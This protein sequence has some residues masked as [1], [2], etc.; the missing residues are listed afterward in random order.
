MSGDYDGINEMILAELDVGGTM[1]PAL[2]HFDR[3]GFGY[4]HEPQDRRT[5]GSGEV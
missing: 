4:T 5:A 2:V 1:T 3:N